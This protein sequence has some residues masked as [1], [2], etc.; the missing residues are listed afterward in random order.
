V[1][2]RLGRACERKRPLRVEVRLR[3]V[4]RRKK[5]ALRVRVR[6][7]RAYKREGRA[8]RV[9]IRLGRKLRARV[10]VIRGLRG[11]VILGR[12]ERAL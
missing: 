8:L 6:L 2:I 9:E 1:R 4:Y 7:G 5:K 10:Q 3:R 11:R 12:E